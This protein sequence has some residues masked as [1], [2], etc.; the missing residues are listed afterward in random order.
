MTYVWYSGKA[1]ASLRAARG[2]L[3]AVQRESRQDAR[4]LRT[5]AS[6]GISVLELAARL[7]TCTGVHVFLMLN[8]PLESETCA[9]NQ[10]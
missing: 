10:H 3:V 1:V 5:A 9:G 2:G 6:V 7:G 4:A 8:L